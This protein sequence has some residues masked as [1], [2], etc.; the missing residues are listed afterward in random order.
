MYKQGLTHSIDVNIAC[1]CG[2]NAAL[3][4]SHITDRLSDRHDNRIKTRQGRVWLND[5]IKSICLDL[6][7]LSH[8][9][10]KDSLKILVDA[11]YLVRE[12]YNSDIFDQTNWYALGVS[13]E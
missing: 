9:Q 12:K 11:G 7:Y 6:P 2:V 13:C 1:I 3:V 10:V 4:Y 5:S 8:H